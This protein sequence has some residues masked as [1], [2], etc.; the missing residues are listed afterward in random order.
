[1]PETV[2]SGLLVASNQRIHIAVC[3]GA[4]GTLYYYGADDRTNLTI[5][6]PATRSADGFTAT[7]NGVTYTI[8]ADHLLV[9][10]AGRTLEDEDLT[11]GWVG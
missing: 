3:S 1:M 8:S 5:T 9:A 10:K 4:S 7:N 2:G 6:L 11:S